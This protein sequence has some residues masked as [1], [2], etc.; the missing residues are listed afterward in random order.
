MLRAVANVRGECLRA[1][2][3]SSDKD[4]G[5]RRHEP[6]PETLEMRREPVT[7]IQWKGRESVPVVSQLLEYTEQIELQ[8]APEYNHALFEKLHP[9]APRAVVEQ[10]D[11]TGGAEL[12]NTVSEIRGLEDMA[13]L[14]DTLAAEDVSLHIISPPAVIIEVPDPGPAAA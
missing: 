3:R 12:L 4:F 2:H 5:Y 8:L 9:E 10:V 13:L 1:V 7:R 6:E 14:V 11:R